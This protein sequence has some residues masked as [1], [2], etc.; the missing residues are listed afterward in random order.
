VGRRPPLRTLPKTA[1]R[2]LTMPAAKADYRK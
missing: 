1:S 2:D